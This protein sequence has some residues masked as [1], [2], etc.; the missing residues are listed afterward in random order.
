METK[1]S[2]GEGE[3]DEGEEGDDEV[4]EEK[5]H[6]G[7]GKRK[8]NTPQEKGTVVVIETLVKDGITHEFHIK[9]YSIEGQCEACAIT[10]QEW[11]KG[12]KQKKEIEVLLKWGKDMYNEF[13]NLKPR[14]P[15]L[16]VTEEE[17]WVKA[18]REVS[19]VDKLATENA[20]NEFLDWCRKEKKAARMWVLH[21][22]VQNRWELAVVL[23]LPG[24]QGKYKVNIVTQAKND[25]F[26]T[27][28]KRIF[29][30]DN[31]TPM[32]SKDREWPD[33]KFAIPFLL[34]VVEEM[35]RQPFDEFPSTR[36]VI[37][38]RIV[39]AC[40]KICEHRQR[41]LRGENNRHTLTLQKREQDRATYSSVTTVLGMG[42]KHTRIVVTH[43][44]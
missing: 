4:E 5:E 37:S 40:E 1:E 7:K 42:H 44:L 43:S 28:L 39:F 14:P 24:E 13:N 35:L 25:N 6:I 23:A 41:E 10:A 32:I 18:I 12:S 19:I 33:D 30:Q 36:A 22:I 15:A 8:P 20:A 2:E 21:E 26:W 27:I 34:G 3:G 31:T 17:K 11:R 29:T 16:E 38:E 9:D